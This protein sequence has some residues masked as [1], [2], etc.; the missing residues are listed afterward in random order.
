MKI[1]EDNFRKFY[2]GSAAEYFIQSEFYT[3]GYEAYKA[4]PDIGFDL[5]VTNSGL[6]KFLKEKQQ[7]KTRFMNNSQTVFFIEQEDFEVLL[8]YDNSA[9]VCVL[10]CPILKYDTNPFYYNRDTFILDS[11]YDD[12][13]QSY[14]EWKMSQ[15]EE[16]SVTKADSTHGMIFLDINGDT[17]PNVL[18]KDQFYIPL[19]A[20]GI[21]SGS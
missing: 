17:D 12:L 15:E 20:D 19:V 11:M 10:Q 18:G 21:I 9:L 7:V 16:I 14:V 1:T 5:C 6:T 2:F 13:D 3:F 8:D 4:Q